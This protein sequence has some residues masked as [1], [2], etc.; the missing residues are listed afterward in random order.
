MLSAHV[1]NAH[2]ARASFSISGTNS[3]W[4]ESPPT[5]SSGIT[6]FHTKSPPQNVNYGS[7]RRCCIGPSDTH[8]LQVAFWI[9]P[10]VWHRPEADNL[11]TASATCS[12]SQTKG[13]CPQETTNNRR[14][15]CRFQHKQVY[16]ADGFLPATVA[17]PLWCYC[18]CQ[19]CMLRFLRPQTWGAP[20]R[21]GGGGQLWRS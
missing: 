18:G 1:E 8:I 20:T 6:S 13:A 7:G 4:Q 12:A 16:Q 5:T 3:N 10:T 19:L 11:T 14:Y 9:K 17:G 21:G 2:T 15:G